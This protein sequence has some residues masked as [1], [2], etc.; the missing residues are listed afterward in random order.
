MKRFITTMS[1]VMIACAAMLLAGCDNDDN[2]GNGS[3]KKNNGASDDKSLTFFCAAGMKP[4]IELIRK[5]YEKQYGVSAQ[6]QYEGSGTLFSKIQ[7]A[8]QGD[9]FLAA[10]ESYVIAAQEKGLVKESIPLAHLTPV[11]AVK[12]GNAKNIKS[13]DDLLREDVDVAVGNPDAA[14]VGRKTRKILKGTGHWDKLEGHIKVLKPTVNDIANDIIIGSVDAGI[15]WD[16]TANQYPDIEIIRVEPFEKKSMK[17]TIGVMTS[18]EN[19]TEALKFARYVAASDK[20][21]THFKSAGYAALNGD[22]WE[23]HPEILIYSGAMLRPGLEKTIKEF[24]KREGCTIN[25][26]F[27]GCGLLVSQMKAGA[28]PEA[29][30]S[31]DM[32]F[33]EAVEDRFEP[34]TVLTENDMVIL[35][36]KGNE[37]NIKNLEDLTRDGVRV[38]V[39]H[40]KNSALGALTAMML[41]D[42][43]LYDKVNANKSLDSATGDFLVNQIRA[44]SLDAVIVYRSNAM[45]SPENMEKY[46][47]IVDIEAEG[48][49]A[50]QPIAIAKETKHHHMIERFFKAVRS[51]ASRE[52]FESFGFRWRD[53][54]AEK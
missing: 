18:S 29:Y 40:E 20:G 44:G 38:G 16:A 41:K 25:T 33:M 54:A 52:N 24:Q 32:K 39:A 35:V 45:S 13:L 26:V 7:I 4:P 14:A 53:E 28:K 5:E 19:P 48:A 2:P 51:N 15:I 17:V 11:I 42:A 37:K 31:C 27:N 12:K 43:G 1:A 50:V 30:L 8:K 22:A 34:S 36:K 46:L 23:E 21:L 6:I 47:D 49:M 9:L 3:T 10:D